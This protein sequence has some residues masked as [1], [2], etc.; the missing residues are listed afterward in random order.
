MKADPNLKMRITYREEDLSRLE[1]YFKTVPNEIRNR[2]ELIGLKD[3][4]L[5]RSWARDPSML[6]E[7][8]TMLMSRDR[9]MG[10]TSEESEFMSEKAMDD[11]YHSVKKYAEAAGIKA[12]VSAFRF[13][14]GNVVVGA[15]HIFVGAD[16]VH[17]AMQDYGIKQ[18]DQAAVEA[19]QKIGYETIPAHSAFE[20]FKNGGGPRCLT[21]ACRI[22]P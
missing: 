9:M 21:E 17:S 20:S 18:L 5:Q 3:I 22:H 15:Q 4:E 11:Y 19:Y 6:A 13:E 7:D 12:K 8:G 1:H 14:G 2:F 10:A 16:V